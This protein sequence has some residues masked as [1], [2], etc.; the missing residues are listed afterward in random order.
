MAIRNHRRGGK[1]NF[2]QSGF[3]NGTRAR[4]LALFLCLCMLAGFLPAQ[5]AAADGEKLNEYVT[6]YTM[7][8]CDTDKK[9]IAN[10]ALLTSG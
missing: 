1:R 10:G 8:L 9:S 7:D 3:R 5:T 6:S 4:L 2:N